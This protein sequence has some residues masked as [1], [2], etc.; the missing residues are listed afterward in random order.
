MKFCTEC[1]KQVEDTVKY[2]INCGKQ[3]PQIPPEI[4]QEPPVKI[5]NPQNKI[6][7][8]WAVISTVLLIGAIAAWAVFMLPELMKNGENTEASD[9]A[10]DKEEYEEYKEDEEEG[11]I[12]DIIYEYAPELNDKITSKLAELERKVNEYYIGE[13]DEQKLL[14]SVAEGYVYGLGD[15]YAEYMNEDRYA[16]YINSNQGRMFGIGVEVIYSDDMGGVIEVTYVTP[17]SP[18]EKGGMLEGDYI[19]KVEGELVSEL[20]YYETINRVRGEKGTDVALTIL[21]GETHSD[22]LIFIFTRD[23]VKLI[24]VKSR[25]IK[26]D[27]GY[28][29]IKEFNQET[30]NEFI[31]AIYELESMGAKQYIFDVRNNPGGDLLGVTQTLDYLLPE[32]PIIRYG[33]KNSVEG[34]IDSDASEI[35][36]PMAVL[37]NE[38]TA[39]AG[40]LFCAALKDYGKAVLI[41]VKTFGKGTMQGI[42][43]LNDRVTAIKISNAKYYPPFSDCYDGIGVS[44][45][46]EV[47]LPDELLGKNLEKITEEEDVQLRAAIEYL[48]KQ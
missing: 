25:M 10:T 29:K 40:E 1:G 36:A 8:I 35:I 47:K 7:V 28:I 30:P 42:Y 21:R 48:R 45:H 4:K 37:I 22:E 14:D 17:D 6:F 18:A 20:G 16:E 46:I 33:Y 41:G 15:R 24:T 13:I 5:T 26:G 19:Y 12:K 11:D 38:N 32:G 31:K 2:C 34:S 23:E 39:S 27:T 43:Q 9:R 3:M 44:P